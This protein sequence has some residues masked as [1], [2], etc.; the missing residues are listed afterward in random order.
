M[1]L[2]RTVRVLL[3]KDLLIALRCYLWTAF[4]LACPILLALLMATEGKEKEELKVCEEKKA[5]IKLKLESVQRF[6]GRM[7]LQTPLNYVNDGPNKNDIEALL[8][9]YVS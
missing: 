6:E 1:S 3:L 5:E 4:Q 7:C 8:K 2:F 9:P